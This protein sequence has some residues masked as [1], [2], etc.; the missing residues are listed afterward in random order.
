MPSDARLMILS[1]TRDKGRTKDLFHQRI[2]FHSGPTRRSRRL[3]Q[4]R[5]RSEQCKLFKAMPKLIR[6]SVCMEK[7]QRI[8]LYV[9]MIV[10]RFINFLLALLYFDLAI[11]FCCE[12]VSKEE[13][14][15]IEI[16]IHDDENAALF[17][18]T[19]SS[20]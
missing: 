8:D 6:S 2:R 4:S 20:W 18:G 17:C 19:P 7:T 3:K 1:D 12:L 15:R 14:I 10:S 13:H 5:L 9:I 11:N 16:L